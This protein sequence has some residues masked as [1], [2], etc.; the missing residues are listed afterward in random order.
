MEAAGIA[1]AA[2]T[3]TLGNRAAAGITGRAIQILVHQGQCTRYDIFE[4]G[5]QRV[6]TQR[7][8]PTVRKS[9]V[10]NRVTRATAKAATTRE[11]TIT[12]LL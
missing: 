6:T 10:R 11:T 3:Q 2:M 8:Y 1:N 12:P 4:S 5:P 7:R 9:S